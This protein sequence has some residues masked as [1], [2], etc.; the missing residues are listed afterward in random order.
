MEK[1][2][3]TA[4]GTIAVI[5]VR[6]GSK[7]IPGKN[8][9]SLAG[10]PLLHWTLSAAHDCTNISSIIVSSDDSAILKCAEDFGSTKVKLLHRPPELATD[11]ATSESAL[12]HALEGQDFERAILLQ[13]TSPLTTAEDLSAALE[14]MDQDGFD[15]VLSVTHEFRFRW[16]RMSDGVSAENYDP[17]ARPRRQ[18]WDGE[19][20]ENGAFYITTRRALLSSRC[21]ISGKTG[22]WVM[23]NSTAVEIDTEEDWGVVEK[24][25]ARRNRSPRS[26]RLLVS[27]VDGVLTDGGM[28][29]GADGEALKKFNTRDAMGMQL[30]RESGRDIALVTGEDSA[31]VRSR[32]QKLGL[33]DVHYG[34]KDKLPVLRKLC[35]EKGL[36]MSQVAYIGDDINDLEC[37]Q[38][39]G[40]SAC[41]RDADPAVWA[42]CTLTLQQGGGDGCLRELINHLLALEKP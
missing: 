2:L 30:W 31:A 1:N 6:G 21:R 39:A 38:H 35:S 24:L 29:Y 37:L 14:L 5:P 10:R 27:D 11:T 23:P 41:P 20:L 36:S 25:I 40:L 19:L 42:H 17:Q 26:I 34:I 3:S 32:A 15:S 18:D 8:I 4:P 33:T 16:R 9:K 22:A 12:L 13:A 7:S 28:Y